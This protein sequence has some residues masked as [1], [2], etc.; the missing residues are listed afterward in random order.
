MTTL[1]S[2]VLDVYRKIAREAAS[3]S[4]LHKKSTLLAVDVQSAAKLVLPGEIC[5]HALSAG[6]RAVATYDSSIKGKK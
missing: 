6:S 4:R 2:I 5:K 1:N 3:M